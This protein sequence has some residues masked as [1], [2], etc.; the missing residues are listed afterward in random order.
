MS[1]TEFNN[2]EGMNPRQEQ[3]IIALLNEPTVKRAA[4]SA[5]MGERTIYRWMREPAFRR[6]YMNARR[7]AFAHA[8]ALTQRYAPLAVQTLAQ[9]M[10]DQNAPYAARVA[11]AVSLLRFSR[12]SV[13][14]DDL[15]RRVEQIEEAVAGEGGEKP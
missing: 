15:S 6:A 5:N 1:E 7:E 11:A 8:V 4:E 9:I 14:L 13:E 3:A 10:V 12:E 2:F